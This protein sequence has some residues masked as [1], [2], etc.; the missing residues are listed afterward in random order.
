MYNFISF[1]LTKSKVSSTYCMYPFIKDLLTKSFTIIFSNS[2]MIIFA[3]T[4]LD[5][6]NAVIEN[7]ETFDH[8]DNWAHLEY[9]EAYIKTM[10][11]EIN[12]R[13]EAS[14]EL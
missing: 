8:N 3:R 14:K 9:L 12:I 6:H 11:P 2:V 1:S 5:L 10:S 4:E 13:L 7:T